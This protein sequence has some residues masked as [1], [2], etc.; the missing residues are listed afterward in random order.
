L[1]RILPQEATEHFVY[2]L[3]VKR[4]YEKHVRY[5]SPANLPHE[6]LLALETAALSAYD[7]LGCRDL[8]RIDFRVR[9]G[10]R[11]A[12]SEI[13]ELAAVN[14]SSGDKHTHKNMH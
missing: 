3:E 13:A 5:E 12:S 8:C 7:A 6:T 1:E 2:S 4:E 10:V 11:L 14:I 9:D